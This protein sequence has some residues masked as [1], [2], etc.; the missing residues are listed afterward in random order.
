MLIAI[1]G[2]KTN[3]FAIMILL[4]QRNRPFAR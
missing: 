4:N 3:R 2:L 1:G